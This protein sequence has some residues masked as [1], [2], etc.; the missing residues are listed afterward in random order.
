MRLTKDT[1]T[2]GYSTNRYSGAFETEAEAEQEAA[3]FTKR[4]FG[5]MGSA[6]VR[7]GSDGLWHVSASCF[8][9][10]E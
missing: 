1:S 3:Q 2:A 9:T 4:M 7:K 6:S 5:S 8:S 10:C